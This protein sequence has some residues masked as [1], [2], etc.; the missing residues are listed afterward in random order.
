MR[1]IVFCCLD[2]VRKDVF[3]QNADELRELADV[4]FEQC[5]AASSWSAPS[6]ASLLT[7]TLPHEH[8]VHTYNYDYSVIP[9][10]DTFL[11]DLPQEYR[12]I[13]VTGNPYATT[14]FNFDKFFDTFVDSNP[15]T[16]D[17]TGASKY[18]EFVGKALRH[19]N[20]LRNLKDGALRELEKFSRTYPAGYAP[21][22]VA[23]EARN[24]ILAGK[25]PYFLFL[26]FMN[27]HTPRRKR[28]RFHAEVDVNPEWDS[29]DYDHWD[30]QTEGV[31]DE[32]RAHLA[33]ERDLY[34]VIVD[35][36]DGK[37]A[38]FVEAIQ[39]LSEHETTFIIT[40]DHGEN[41]GYPHEQ[42]LVGHQSSLSES[43]LHVPFLLIN[44]PEG[45]DDRESE[46]F[47]HLS[48]PNMIRGMVAEETPY[49]FES[50]IA[51][52]R[53]G[54]GSGISSLPADVDAEYWDR[55]IRVAY[56]DDEKYEWD[57]LG[58]AYRRHLERHRPCWEGD[59]ETIEMIPTFATSM[60]DRDIQSYRDSIDK[61][62][63]APEDLSEEVRA[64]LEYLGYL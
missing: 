26:N 16:V 61:K 33:N 4:S 22:W 20:P 43:L 18:L 41:L 3:D 29:T 60:F 50:A 2:T 1:N 38:T 40:A 46:Y 55:T 39:R 9:Y 24:Q 42:R 63:I 13:A 10:E 7:G 51:A 35:Y 48:V 57:S 58:N 36:L 25:E 49:V 34:R 56:R 15:L 12:S 30:I 37:I 32:L 31:D 53:V 6:H 52:E 17:G 62:R 44:P 19:P 27:A 54:S 64:E 5:R 8:G 59:P 23:R 14:E 11:A 28:A 45:Y 21:L 47:S